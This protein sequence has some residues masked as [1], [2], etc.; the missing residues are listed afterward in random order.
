MADLT[1]TLLPPFAV[2]SATPQN[3]SLEVVNSRV[4]LQPPHFHLVAFV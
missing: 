3:V 2:P 4:S 1:L